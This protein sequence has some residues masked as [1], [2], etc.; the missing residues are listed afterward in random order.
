MDDL[1]TVVTAARIEAYRRD[2]AVL[3]P[4][5]VSTEWLSV[6]RQGIARNLANRGP[7]AAL[8]VDDGKGRMFFEDAGVWRQN[9]EYRRFL[10]ES[11]MPVV[12]ARLTG[13]QSLRIFFDNIFIK[14]PGIDAP[15]PWHQDLPYTPMEGEM[16]SL[17]VALDDIAEQHSLELIAGSHRWDR[18]FRPVSFAADPVDKPG[19]N[20]L[21]RQP[22]AA[23]LREENTVLNWPVAAGD[24]IAFDGMTLH[25]S[26]S[27][28]GEQR[29]HSFIARYAVD[30]AI[31]T[32]RGPGE[33]PQFPDCG[34]TTGV[35]LDGAQ[36][37][38]V[39]LLVGQP[40]PVTVK[41]ETLLPISW[42][43]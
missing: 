25:A 29:R 24:V 36:F 13:Q 34:L 39:D 3:L 26:N 41:E 28:G 22:D 21:E 17:W 42:Q 32:P 8:R 30:G 23:K 11:L 6:I 1:E 20:T 37:P 16:C 14:D 31:F 38:L 2:G 5:L 19:F 27:N 12:A 18:S 7:N 35:P 15:T 10:V 4:G 9:P 43:R 33:Y 40:T